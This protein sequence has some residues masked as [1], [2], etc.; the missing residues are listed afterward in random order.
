MNN[1]QKILEILAQMQATQSRM[2]ADIAD[3]KETQSTMQT[4]LTRMAVTQETAVIPQIKLLAEGHKTLLNTPWPPKP[5][6]KP[7]KMM[8]LC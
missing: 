2:Q 1:E 5:G 4:T 7:W 8:S 6:Q 3:L